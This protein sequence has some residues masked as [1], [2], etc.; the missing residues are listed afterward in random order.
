MVPAP[1]L[2]LVFGGGSALPPGA[3]ED[4]PVACGDGAT[5]GQPGFRQQTSST[6][7]PSRKA[8]HTSPRGQRWL[9]SQRMAPSGTLGWYTQAAQ[10]IR[11]G[12]TSLKNSLD[13]IAY[14]KARAILDR[15]ALF[16]KGGHETY[17]VMPKEPATCCA[18]FSAGL[19]NSAVGSRG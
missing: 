17:C 1:G 10:K 12:N 6:V 5:P 13:P 9:S 7:A 11:A 16:A 4:A 15:F 2:P 8:L 18:H 3:R 19:G 14:L